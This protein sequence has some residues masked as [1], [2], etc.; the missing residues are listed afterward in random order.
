MPRWAVA[1][2][3][4]GGGL[5]SA[6]APQSLAACRSTADGPHGRGSEVRAQFV[7]HFSTGVCSKKN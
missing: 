1:V 7:C 6:L 2:T 4:A 5:A 3:A